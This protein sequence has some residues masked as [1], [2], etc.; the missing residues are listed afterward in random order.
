MIPL[1]SS[2]IHCLPSTRVM[3]HDS[4]SSKISN[5]CQQF[6]RNST[7]DIMAHTHKTSQAM[8]IYFTKMKKPTDTFCTHLF[9]ASAIIL[10]FG[11]LFLHR[12]PR[13]LKVNLNL[14]RAPTTDFSRK[15]AEPGG[16]IQIQVISF[17]RQKRSLPKD[18]PKIDP[19]FSAKS[20]DRICHILSSRVE[21][22]EQF[23]FD[24][25]GSSVIVDNS[26]NSYIR[27]EE[28]IFNDKIEPIISNGVATIG[29]NN[30]ITKGIGT[31]IWSCTYDEGKLHTNKLNNL[32]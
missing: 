2:N 27:S 21:Y 9:F 6:N 32:L 3:E 18:A 7:Q 5:I 4:K 16:R 13:L 30:L 22:S 25:D 23:G 19:L 28:Y 12:I 26:D 8:H 1:I 20:T 11:G 15:N 31:V 17:G 29:G 10:I 24:S 14:I